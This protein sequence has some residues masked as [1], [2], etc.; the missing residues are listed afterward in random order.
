MS[1]L[2]PSPIRLDLPA[3]PSARLASPAD[4]DRLLL[5]ELLDEALSAV[6]PL[7][8]VPPHLPEP[9]RGGGRT[10]V[11][12]AGKAA[13]RMALAV[14]QHW[15]GPLSG[16]VVTRY[17]HGEPTRHI[18]VVEAAHPLPDA[19]GEAAA[20]HML[21]WAGSARE[22]DLVLCLISGG[23]SALLSLP[24]DGV[25]SE[26]KRAVTHALLRSGAPIAEINCV[27]RHLSAVKGGKLGL[28]CGRARVATLVL[29]DVPGDDPAAVA[30]GPTIADDSTP[31]DALAILRKHGIP[32]SQQVLQALREAVST[33]KPSAEAGPRSVEVVAR[34][35]DALAR[36]G[37]RAQELG[38]HTFMLGGSIE[39][40]SREVAAVHAGIARHIVQHRNPAPPCVIL[41]GG[42]TTV[43]VRGNGRGGRNAEF[44][45]AL[46]L[47]SQGLNT[48]HALACD[49]DGIDGVEDNAG[50]VIGPDTLARAAVLGLDPREYLA[51][52]DAYGFFQ[53]LG[54]LVFT[55]PTRTNVNDFR[56]VLLR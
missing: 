27:R 17:G 29:S 28:A 50:A 1:A 39:G 14:E 10:I 25:P 5:I 34:A 55:G 35:Q 36:A 54:G 41:S 21:Q 53:Q 15:P 6:D 18:R 31:A 43:T 9:P 4:N 56:A 16:M 48:L 51:R 11:L 3:M 24:I 52:N 38:L 23:G 2:A 40:E 32:T 47:A 37:W 42:E 8:V 45:L 22:G 30:S 46:A 33:A 12:G 13:A 44:L 49:T 20:R 26:H 7:N 19:A